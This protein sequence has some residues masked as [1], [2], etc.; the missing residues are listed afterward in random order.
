MM[1]Y[2]D[3]DARLIEALRDDARRS[4]R[5][6]GEALGVSTSTV[7]NHL[8]ELE[9]S[10]VISGYRPVVDYSRLGYGLVAVIRIKARGDALPRIVEALVA[11]DRLTHVYEITGEFDVMVIGRFRSE[12]EMNREIKRL[13][14]LPGIEGTNT[15]IVLSAPKEAGD[16]SLTEADR[17]P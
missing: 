7:R 4:L 14:G 12:T 10:G 5:E 6:L 17:S 16:I 11:D 1:A 9:E 13:L 8:H 15:S 3:L 2:Q